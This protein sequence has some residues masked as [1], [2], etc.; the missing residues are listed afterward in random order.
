MYIMSQ[1]TSLHAVMFVISQCTSLHAVTTSQ[2]S[3]MSPPRAAARRLLP[4]ST[5]QSATQLTASSFKGSAIGED[6]GHHVPFIM[7]IPHH[8]RGL[9][10]LLMGSVTRRPW[11]SKCMQERSLPKSVVKYLNS[12]V[13][14]Q[15]PI[16]Y[17]LQKIMRADKCCCLSSKRCIRKSNAVVK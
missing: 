15:G 17:T 3:I 8:R 14:C 1:R 16:N 10:T 5:H 11:Q 12:K 4:P 6:K 2:S 13:C 7:A 9:R